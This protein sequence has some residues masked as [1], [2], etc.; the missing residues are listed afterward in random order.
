MAYCHTCL[1]VAFA[2]DDVSSVL[3]DLIRGLGLQVEMPT[4]ARHCLYA[5]DPPSSGLRLGQQVAVVCDWSNL[6]NTGEVE[7]EIRSSE[8]M[9]LGSTRAEDL[10]RQLCN[11]LQGGR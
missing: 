1:P 11:L 3:A 6:P 10:F 4:N 5:A 2:S 7:L 9:A 8:S